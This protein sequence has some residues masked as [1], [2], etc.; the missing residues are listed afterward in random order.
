MKNRIFPKYLWF[1]VGVVVALLLVMSGSLLGGVVLGSY[2][3][4]DALALSASPPVQAA[5]PAAQLS[6]DEANLIAAY[7]QA[8]ID[9]YRNAVPSVV[10]IIDFR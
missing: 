4:S 5:Q 9:I 2:L 6:Q 8:L 3:T 10:N 1:G 7:E